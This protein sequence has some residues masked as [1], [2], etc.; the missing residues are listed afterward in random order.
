MKFTCKKSDF[1]EAVLTAS[2]AVSPKSSIPALE[3]ILI[4]AGQNLTFCGYDLKL[5][6]TCSCEADISEGGSIILNSRLLSEIARK[7]PDGEVFIS[8]NDSD[9]L[10]ILCGLSEY[11]LT[12]IPG[13]EFPEM[14]I[15]DSDRNFSIP[16]DVLKKM[17]AG[18]IFSV[19]TN[20]T[21]PVFTGCLFDIRE[22]TLKI[23]STDTFRLSVCRTAVECEGEFKFVVPGDTLR[24][25][26]R[27]LP[28]SDEKAD[29]ELAE[30]HILVRIGSSIIFSGLLDGQFLRYENTI[31][32]PQKNSVTISVSKLT[33]CVDRVSP[34]V[35][36]KLRN[37]LRLKLE[38]GTIRLT[39]TS[40]T[41]NAK[42][43]S[44]YSG[45]CDP[46]EVG[47]SNKFLLDAL[48]AIPDEEC[49]L[50]FNSSTSPFVLR[51][52]DGEDY[53]YMIALMR[54]S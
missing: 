25:I 32:T 29:F 2:R 27:I 48:H 28:D 20:D 1:S 19:S 40:S 44:S 5:G 12:G 8:T 38:D 24:E 23:V 45:Q 30:K 54:L 43:E 53:F 41:A 3:G 26:A 42:D 52:K 39:Y 7:L 16:S 15:I 46:V 51:Q 34:V 22:G 47:L 11:N 18:T 17:I 9:K 31:S 37:P 35:N 10:K 4:T 13:E 50:C 21:K 33:E 36:D 14:P 49:E 6:I